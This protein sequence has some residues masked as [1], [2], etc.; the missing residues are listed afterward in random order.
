MSLFFFD[1][2]DIEFHQLHSTWLIAATANHPNI[3]KAYSIELI[4]SR[5][6]TK[7]KPKGLLFLTLLVL[8]A[9]HIP[10]SLP[11]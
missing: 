2:A 1:A 10:E 6:T 3:T 7:V 5:E 4:V 8:A 9:N 11:N